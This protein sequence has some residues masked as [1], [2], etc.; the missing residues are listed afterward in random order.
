MSR[1]WYVVL[2]LVGLVVT[3]GCTLPGADLTA[4]ASPAVVNDSALDGSGYAVEERGEIAIN[5][6]L[7]IAG[8]D[9]KVG[10]TNH[11]VTYTSDEHE[12]QFAVFSTPSPET[13]GAPVNPFVNKSERRDVARMFGE[14][15]NTTALTVADRR[16][17][18]ALGQPTEVVTYETE[19]RTA[20][21]T[22]PVLVHVAVIEDRGD[23][24][25]AVGVHPQS[26]EGTETMDRLVA[27]LEHG[28]DS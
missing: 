24:V 15:N 8:E 16:T 19:N 11:I 28:E 26:V 2:A 5:E 18:T 14:L 7:G 22:M 9:R 25:V 13:D 17:V 20:T 4:E 27:G 6:T 3:S 12:G 10:V 21:G 23:A 1:Y